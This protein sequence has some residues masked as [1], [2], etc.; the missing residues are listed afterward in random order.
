MKNPVD[1]PKDDIVV[2]RVVV[3]AAADRSAAGIAGVIEIVDADAS[4][5]T[6]FMDAAKPIT[7]NWVEKATEAGIDAEAAL[8][9]YKKRL[10]ELNQ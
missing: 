8:A 9:F 3:V 2:I 6:A 7:A 5:E 1:I 4:L 10:A